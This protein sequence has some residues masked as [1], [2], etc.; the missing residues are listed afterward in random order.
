MK[1]NN[2]IQLII[3]F[4][5]LLTFSLCSC[6][7][8]PKVSKQRSETYIA[9]LDS[10]YVDELHLYTKTPMGEPRVTDIEVTFFPRTNII[11]FKMKI[12]L[13]VIRVGFSYAERKRLYESALEYLDSY[14]SNTIQYS[15]PNKQNA[16]L[17]SNTLLSWG[18]FGLTHDVNVK[19]YTNIEYLESEKPYY[20]IK[21][22][23]TDDPEDGS[24]TP[25]FSIYIS[26]SQWNSIF[27]ICNQT[28]LE[29]KCEEILE[30]ADAF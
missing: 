11:G 28:E 8:K 26:P 12:G 24:A 3:I 9:D 27:E 2:I 1:K 15:K 13:D 7:S 10:F 4:T 6:A 21:F 19:Y 18:V 22:E 29:S 20:R 23:A 14:N 5:V 16:L 25:P 17:K 30:K